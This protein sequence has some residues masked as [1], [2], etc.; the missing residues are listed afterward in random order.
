M[1]KALMK[2]LKL[3][4]VS[5]LNIHVQSTDFKVYKYDSCGMFNV[6]K[7]DSCGIS[8]WQPFMKIEFCHIKKMDMGQDVNTKVVPIKYIKL[9]L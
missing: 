9:K 4:I 5:I 3:T 8:A 6:Y 7:Y 1:K 2:M